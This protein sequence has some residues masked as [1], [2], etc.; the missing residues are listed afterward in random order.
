MT[1]RLKA[2][3][4]AAFVAALAVVWGCGLAVTAAEASDRLGLVSSDP[5]ADSTMAHLPTEIVLTFSQPLLSTTVVSV[6]APDGEV[7]SSG[8]VSVHNVIAH[9]AIAGAGVAGVYTVAYTAADINGRTTPGSFA[10]TVTVG[11]APTGKPGKGSRTPSAPPVVAT[12]VAQ[13]PVADTVTRSAGAAVATGND[14]ALTISSTPAWWTFAGAVLVIA[15]VLVV[16]IGFRR[17][18]PANTTR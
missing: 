11:S 13:A 12:T 2:S 7:L 5:V 9:V 8:T 15:C 10:F 14:T 18:T 17:R 3:L 16:F 4:L 1:V 6:T